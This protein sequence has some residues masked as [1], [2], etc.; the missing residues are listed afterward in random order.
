MKIEAVPVATAHGVETPA[1][2]LPMEN[3][4]ER[5]PRQWRC[6]GKSHLVERTMPGGAV[7]PHHI[8]YVSSSA[9]LIAASAVRATAHKPICVLWALSA[10]ATGKLRTCDIPERVCDDLI[11]EQDRPRA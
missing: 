4:G 9:S 10:M 8:R 3:W 6:I 5:Q 2:D 1:V 11:V 7:K